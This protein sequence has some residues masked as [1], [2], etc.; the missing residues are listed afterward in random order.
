MYQSLA[1]IAFLNI[2]KENI[3][4]IVVVL[5]IVF[6]IPFCF[7]LKPKVH[8]EYNTVNIAYIEKCKLLEQIDSIVETAKDS[9][10]DCYLGDLERIQLIQ[11]SEPRDTAYYVYKGKYLFTT[12]PYKP[13]LQD[14][15]NIFEGKIPSHDLE[16]VFSGVFLIL[17]NSNAL[18]SDGK[19]FFIDDY[20][21][22]LLKTEY[23][24]RK[25]C[26]KQKYWDNIPIYYNAV[27]SMVITKDGTLRDIKYERGQRWIKQ[28]Y[29]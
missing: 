25:E 21:Y 17:D 1:S 23:S 2:R 3:K 18:V 26:I 29:K 19:Y 27:F 16:I 20:L 7:S 11:I 4:V 6:F 28:V 5:I 9:L 8:V 24:F 12:E 10:P 13:K 15:K 14:I 22:S